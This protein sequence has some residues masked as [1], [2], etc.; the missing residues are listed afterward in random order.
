VRDTSKRE[1]DRFEYDDSKTA[2]VDKTPGCRLSASDGAA[3]LTV[4]DASPA[5]EIVVEL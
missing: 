2:D 4:W 1:D 5:Y 3:T